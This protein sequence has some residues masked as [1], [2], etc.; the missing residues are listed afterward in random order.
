MNSR[1]KVELE[2]LILGLFESRSVITIHDVA[3]S[4]NMSLELSANRR[5]IQRAFKS[6]IEKGLIETH[7]EARAREYALSEAKKEKQAEL[8]DEISLSDESSALLQYLSKPLQARQPVGYSQEFLNSYSPNKT[9]YLNKSQQNELH[10]SGI[11][12]SKIRPAGTYAREILNRLLI[13]LSWNSSRLEGNTYSLLETKRLL[14][15]GEIAK[16][17]DIVE[18]Q[19]ILNHKAAIEYIVAATEVDSLS[20]HEICSVHALLSENLLG[21]PSASGRVRTNIVGISGSVYM[22]LENPHI[23]KENLQIFINK[24]NLIKDP[25]E[26][27]LFSLIHLS[28]L[29]A[30]ADVNK[31]TSR[32]VANIPFIKN[33]LKPLSFIDVN[34]E[35]YARALLGVYE[36]NDISLFRDFF[37]WAYQRSAHRYTA[38]QQSMAQPNALKLHYRT[39]IQEIIRQ[40]IIEKIPGSKITG[41]I[42]DLIKKLN[43][44]SEDEKELMNI[45]EL[46]IISLHEGN[47]ARF[48]ILPKE[49]EEWKKHQ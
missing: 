18:T 21:D 38:V 7:G 30:F 19:M 16:G 15:L 33:N 44:P 32:L 1:V 48:W 45:I 23:L 40:I 34:Q 2:P 26:Q 13:D 3:H 46:E 8:L 24:F 49:Y 31:R 4:A 41:K 39:Q 25:F 29:Q 43:I 36:K 47:I 37:I 5:A 35:M 42:Q 27:S 28:Y 6:L 22:P 10:E 17:K 14:E 9:F 12:D 20:F 11:V